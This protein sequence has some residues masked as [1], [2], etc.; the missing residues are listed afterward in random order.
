MNNINN[1]NNKN[2]MGNYN[3][4]NNTSEKIQDVINEL[5]IIIKNNTDDNRYNKLKDIKYNDEEKKAITDLLNNYEDKYEILMNSLNDIK[6]NSKYLEKNS[7][8]LKQK[9]LIDK[10]WIHKILKHLMNKLDT[11]DYESIPHWGLRKYDYY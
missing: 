10:Q 6:Y 9:E 1:K 7:L 2:M 3:E 8:L 4:D 5:E 11:Y